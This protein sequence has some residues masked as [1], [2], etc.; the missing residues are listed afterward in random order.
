M[1]TKV[2]FKLTLAAR[3]D[4]RRLGFEL[5]SLVDE[6]ALVALSGPLG[7]GKTTFA[8]GAG[9][10]LGVEEPINSPTFTT[11]NEYTSGRLPLVHLDLYRFYESLND[12]QADGSAGM[13]DLELELDELLT[14]PGLVLVEWPEPLG[15]YISHRDHILVSLNYLKPERHA[16]GQGLA[17][18]ES[19]RVAHVSAIGD[20]TSKIVERVRNIYFS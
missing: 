15:E 6:H 12:E 9:E 20:P 4:T 1:T 13:V 19:G 7:A 14:A 5:A 11:I 8:Q 16:K 18:Q 17:N 2:D 10:G 3:H